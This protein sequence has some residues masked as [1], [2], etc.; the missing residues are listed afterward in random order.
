[1]GLISPDLVLFLDIP[2]EVAEARKGFGEEHYETREMQQK[3]RENFKKL[4]DDTW[5][6]I[7]ANKPQE[8][9]FHE[10]LDQVTPFLTGGLDPINEEGLWTNHNKEMVMERCITCMCSVISI[11]CLLYCHSL[12]KM[13]L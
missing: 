5:V 6:V 1:M 3:V 9:V 12:Y 13:A 4:V 2:I 10:C 8:E 7:D 11:L